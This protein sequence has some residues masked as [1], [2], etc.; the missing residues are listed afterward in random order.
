MNDRMRAFVKAWSGVWAEGEGDDRLG[1]KLCEP[2]RLDH[3]P[4]Y[5]LSRTVRMPEGHPYETG[6]IGFRLFDLAL[7]NLSRLDEE[8][9]TEEMSAGGA[10]LKIV[11]ERVVLRGRYALEVKPDPIVDLDTGGNLM[12]LSPEALKPTSAGAD[13][14]GD[15]GN[16]DDPQTDAWLD[17]ARNERQNL[18]QTANGQALL[19]LYDTHNETYDYVFKNNQA[20]TQVWKAGGATKAMASDTSDAVANNAVINDSTKT[21][22][23]GN[24]NVTYN[25][26]AFAQQL[27]VAVACVYSDPDYNP[28]TGPNMQGPY[29]AAAKAAISFG[30]GVGSST[31]NSKDNINEMNSSD[32]YTTVNSFQGS[33][34]D[35]SDD[36]MNQII[37]SQGGPGGGG[38]SAGTSRLVIDEDDRKRIR[39]LYEATM[40]QRAEDASVVGAPLYEGACEAQISGVEAT[41]EITSEDKPGGRRARALL[42][43]LELPAFELDIDDSA[44]T[45]ELGELAR[46]RIER[47][48]FIRSLLHG[49]IVARLR[50]S[51]T[52]ASEKA[53]NDMLRSIK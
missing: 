17:Q 42:A 7:H 34:P 9:C 47:M 4:A 31:N 20:L 43:E 27:N 6:A 5:P 48:Y 30:M 12:E 44:W 26:N 10:R 36:E 16:G 53:Y 24:G 38:S 35:V 41:F 8:R 51:L 11:L 22:D 32:V 23:T 25:G 33:L 2:L 19:S 1:E 52:A 18:S 15:G 3:A 40:K 46:N 39:Y 28:E 37:A 29:W 49:S 45:G 13:S 14:N 21:Y 50:Q